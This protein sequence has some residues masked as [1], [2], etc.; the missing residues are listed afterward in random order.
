MTNVIAAM[1]LFAF[2]GAISPGP[3]N[4][5]ATSIGVQ[6]GFIRALPHVTGATLAYTFMVWVIGLGLQAF[7]LRWPVILD[8]LGY[9]GGFFLL[10]IAYQMVLTQ[11]RAVS[12]TNNVRHIPNAFTGAMAQLLNPKAWLVSISGVSLFVSGQ[13]DPHLLLGYFVLISFL[14]CSIGISSWAL[15]GQ[16]LRRFFAIPA[17]QRYFNWSMSVLLLLSVLTIWLSPHQLN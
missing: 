5:M 12:Q 13:T 15:L 4:I 7:L 17:R 3:V 1:S 11:P 6:Y 16:G 10:Y 9:L 2:V 8:L 14:M